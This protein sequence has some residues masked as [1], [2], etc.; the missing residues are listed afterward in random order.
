MVVPLCL[1]SNTNQTSLP[2][3][4]VAE[5]TVLVGGPTPPEQL[6]LVAMTLVLSSDTPSLPAGCESGV[7]RTHRPP[8]ARRRSSEE[9]RSYYLLVDMLGVLASYSITVKE[10]KLLFSMLRGEGGLWPRHA[11]KLLAVLNQMPQRHGP[12]AFFNFPGRSAAAIAL[13]PIAKWPYQ[14]GFSLNTWFRMDP[15]NNINV[16]KDKPYLYCVELLK[17]LHLLSDLHSVEE[18]LP[19][20][21][22]TGT[23]VEVL[24]S[25]AGVE[26]DVLLSL[27]DEGVS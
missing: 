14:S 27:R 22:W 7:L 8:V 17:Q 2:F 11:V 21:G 16:D 26:L 1:R 9:S 18:S 5:C 24:R 15:L 3:V 6:E 20:E 4:H 23:P 13:P 12:D 19:V 10:L 25:E